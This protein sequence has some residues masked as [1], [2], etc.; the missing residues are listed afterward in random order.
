MTE[1]LIRK[2]ICGPGSLT[3]Q[4][5]REILAQNHLTWGEYRRE[6]TGSIE[7]RVDFYLED[8]TTFDENLP[9]SF[10]GQST[11]NNWI[12][13]TTMRL[14]EK[15]TTAEKALNEYA[16]W[17]ANAAINAKLQEKA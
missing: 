9:Q 12:N 6:V 8:K 2:V 17:K 10:I 11:I 14:R 4:E 3:P 5:I 7:G 15:A 1:I 13:E 16:L